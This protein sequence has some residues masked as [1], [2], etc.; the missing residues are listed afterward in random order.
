[1]YNEKMNISE[2]EDYVFEM[3][4]NVSA[5]PYAETLPNTIGGS[6]NDMLLIDCNRGV[7]DNDG[8]GSG[9]IL[10]YLYA[11]PRS[12]GTKNVAKLKQMNNAVAQILENQDS[13]GSYNLYRIK[14]YSDYDYSR[15]WHC[16]VISLGITVK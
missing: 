16:D 14:T 6:W 8:Y 11:R 1:M 2:V 4:K 7:K 3:F 9:I 13:S 5:H 10:L 15:N 12:N